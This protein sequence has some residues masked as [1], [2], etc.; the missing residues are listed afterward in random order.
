MTTAHG[1]VFHAASRRNAASATS[2]SSGPMMALSHA[3]IAER[4]A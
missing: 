2:R 4:E 1:G 3:G